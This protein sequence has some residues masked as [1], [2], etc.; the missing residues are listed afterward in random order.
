MK[1]LILSL[2]LAVLFGACC[3]DHSDIIPGQNFIPEDVLKAIED[4]GQVIYKGFNP[5]DLPGKYLMSPAVLVSSNFPDNASPGDRFVDAIIE[6]YDYNPSDLTLKVRIEEIGESTGEGFGSFISGNGNNF[7]VYV[8][9]ETED[10]QGHKFL[11]TD[12]YS[13]TLESG[14]IRDLQ[15]SGFMVDDK[16]DPNNEYIENGQGRLAEDGDGFSEKI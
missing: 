13:G 8:K 14:G 4:N 10:T 16:G 5:P 1:Y 9:V 12:V 2:S 11:Q 15:R 6:F 7:T 3:K